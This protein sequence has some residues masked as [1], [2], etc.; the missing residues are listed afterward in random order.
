MAV[1]QLAGELQASIDQHA[2]APAQQFLGTNGR[3]ELAGLLRC[4][5]DLVEAALHPHRRHIDITLGQFPADRGSDFRFLQVLVA[6]L[7]D[8]VTE[9]VTGTPGSLG[10]ISQVGVLLNELQLFARQL[11][12]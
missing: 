9:L 11:G 10:S 1:V 5:T 4:V 3:T 8:A 6:L 2:D 12:A 7:P